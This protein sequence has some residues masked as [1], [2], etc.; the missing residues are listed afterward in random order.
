MGPFVSGPPS[1]RPLRCLGKIPLLAPACG[2]HVCLAVLTSRIT[3]CHIP[4]LP[5]SAL[6]IFFVSL[7]HCLSASP[8]LGPRNT[9]IAMT[10]EAFIPPPPPLQPRAWNPLSGGKTAIQQSLPSLDD[11]ASLSLGQKP[12]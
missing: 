7:N 2:F 10:T 3:A 9:A 6:L 11:K 5:F 8:S 12:A 1:R 4:F